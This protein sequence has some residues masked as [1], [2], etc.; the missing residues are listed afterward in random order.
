MQRM[1]QGRIE[2]EEE[3]GRMKNS[4]SEERLRGEE[5]VMQTKQ[6]IKA[7]QVT[8]CSRAGDSLWSSR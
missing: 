5:H 6:K 1:E 2:L 7:E 8:A 4:V 3:L